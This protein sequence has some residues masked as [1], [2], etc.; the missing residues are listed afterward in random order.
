MEAIEIGNVLKGRITGLTKFGAFVSIGE[1]KTGLVHISEVA[2]AYVT[3]INEFLKQDDV[4]DVKVLSIEG[5]KIGLSIKQ[6]SAPPAFVARP[7]STGNNAAHQSFED[8]L[9]KFIKDSDERHH[10]LKRHMDSK[11]GGRGTRFSGM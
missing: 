11:R 4:V 7:K 3:D 9:S 10:D 8:K 5:D 1:N 2:N 6:A